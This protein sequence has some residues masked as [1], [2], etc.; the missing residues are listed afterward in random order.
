[1]AGIS[2]ARAA[3]REVAD[4]LRGNPHVNGVGVAKGDGGYAVKVNLVADDT[5][6]RRSL[7]GAIGGAP[8]LVEV[9]GPIRA[10]AS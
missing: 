5:E 6:L 10:R 7:P 8:V 2:E 3:K 9:V 1:M 4:L